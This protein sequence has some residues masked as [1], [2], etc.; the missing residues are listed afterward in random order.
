[1]F[2]ENKR[3]DQ[4]VLRGGQRAPDREAAEIA[5]PRLNHRFD[6]WGGV[7][8]VHRGKPTAPRKMHHP[9]DVRVRVHH[10]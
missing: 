3:P 7:F 1:M 6:R 9:I 2:E 8:L 10:I 5:R 4:A